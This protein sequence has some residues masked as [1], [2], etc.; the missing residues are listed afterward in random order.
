MRF[1]RWNG[2]TQPSIY[3]FSLVCF[4]VGFATVKL[5]APGRLKGPDQNDKLP[6]SIS[7]PPETAV[8][9]SDGAI[10]DIGFVALAIGLAALVGLGLLWNYIR[11]S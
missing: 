4:F 8:G 5:L 1:P 6:Q 7:A 9:L 11:L 3:V 10:R 2:A